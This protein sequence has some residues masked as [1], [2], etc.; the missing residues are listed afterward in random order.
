[1]SEQPPN[2]KNVIGD[3]G[4]TAGGNASIGDTS[5]SIAIGEYTTQFMIKEPSREALVKL[6]AYLELMSEN[7]SW[8]IRPSSLMG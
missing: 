3:T 5:G 2:S 6:I 7:I 4:I 1:M 8:F